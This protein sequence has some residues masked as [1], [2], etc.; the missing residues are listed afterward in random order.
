MKGKKDERITNKDKEKYD[1]THKFLSHGKCNYGGHVSGVKIFATYR[2]KRE[3]Y[4]NEN[5]N[6]KKKNTLI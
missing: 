6:R 5:I 2:R 4:N 1:T 3:K